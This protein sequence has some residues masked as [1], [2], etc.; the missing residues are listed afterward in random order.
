MNKLIKVHIIF[1]IQ[2]TNKQIFA[3]QIFIILKMIIIK[4]YI[5]FF[6]ELFIIIISL[7]IIKKNNFK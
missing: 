6:G 1:V 2:I 4:I 3:L 7:E 5:Y